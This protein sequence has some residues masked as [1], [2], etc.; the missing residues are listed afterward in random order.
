LIGLGHTWAN[1][2]FG[3]MIS[4]HATSGI[5]L[6][7]RLSGYTDWPRKLRLA[8]LVLVGTSVLIYW[9]LL[10]GVLPRF[11]LP[12]RHE[13]RVVVIRVESQ[14]SIPVRRGDW[15][16]YRIPGW[17]DGPIRLQEGIGFERVQAMAGD[18][19]VFLETHCEVNGVPQPRREYM[20]KEGEWVV[21]ENCWI[22]WPNLAR[23][24]REASVAEVRGVLQAVAYVSTSEYIGRP[25]RHWFWRRQLPL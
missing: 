22:I 4:L 8:F 16:A 20:P 7:L 6:G 5:F 10:N 15:I 3:L 14:P 13:G 12:L 2:A 21:P 19:V 11:V 18:R 17:N 24:G 1:L 25:F 23:R 9:P